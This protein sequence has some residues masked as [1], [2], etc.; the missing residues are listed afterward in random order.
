[1][2][3][4]IARVFAAYHINEP[5]WYQ[6]Q[7]ITNIIGLA[8]FGLE[9]FVYKTARV[10]GPFFAPVIVA[11]IGLAWSIAQYDFYVGK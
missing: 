3:V 2:A 9:A 11:T 10:S 7:M 5:A 8:H 4:G 6:M 1:M